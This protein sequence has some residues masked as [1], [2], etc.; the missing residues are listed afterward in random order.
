MNHNTNIVPAAY[1]KPAHAPNPR[2]NAQLDAAQAG[3]SKSVSSK[4]TS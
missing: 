4:S 2:G 3:G 1:R